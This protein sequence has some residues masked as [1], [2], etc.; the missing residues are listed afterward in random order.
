M[1]LTGVGNALA[2]CNDRQQH[3][4]AEVVCLRC[5][6]KLLF[7]TGA[8]GLLGKG[9]SGPNLLQPLPGEILGRMGYQA[10]KGKC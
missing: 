9:S 5:I 3:A 2:P 6:S 7:D 1:I 10:F 4:A 8:G